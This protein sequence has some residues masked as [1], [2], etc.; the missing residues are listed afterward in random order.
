MNYQEIID[1]ALIYADRKNDNELIGRM[2]S[3]LRVVESR[4]NRA[5]KVMKMTA[6]ATLATV[7]NQEYY[8]LPVDFAGMRDI[9]IRA[10]GGTGRETMKYASPEQ[11]NSYS[12]NNVSGY[13]Y[14]LIADQLQIYPVVENSEIEIVYY[15]KL[16]PLAKNANNWLAND[17]PDVYIF[18]LMVEI[19]SF[20]K[21]A[22]SA[23]MWDERFRNA[24]AE[25]SG[26]DQ[27]SR[28]SGTAMEVRLG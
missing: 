23:A 14:T 7:P 24:L 21:H 6:R 27:L 26:D 19:A 12:T 11:M 15:R 9:E 18:G 22:E 25:V 2:D 10:I 28:W 20:V 4:V 17:M 5:I 1:N 16:T 3:F 13:W 8:G